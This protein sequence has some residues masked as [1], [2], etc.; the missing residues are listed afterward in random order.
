MNRC[1][2]IGAAFETIPVGIHT[3][4]DRL[5]FGKSHS[6]RL[7]MRNIDISALSRAVEGYSVTLYSKSRARKGR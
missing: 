7:Q 1:R 6:S 4:I 2:C 3:L 5:Y